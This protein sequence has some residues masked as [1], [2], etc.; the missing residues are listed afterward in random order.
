MESFSRMELKADQSLDKY[1]EYVCARESIEV[2]NRFKPFD[3][4]RDGTAH[5]R[6]GKVDQSEVSAAVE[7]KWSNLP[8]KLI[9]LKES[10]ELQE[11]HVKKLKVCILWL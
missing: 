11:Q 2:N 9:S 6:H 10:L 5:G 3:T 8:T 1:A 7:P 4:L